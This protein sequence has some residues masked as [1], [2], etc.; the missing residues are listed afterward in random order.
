[1]NETTLSEDQNAQI[2]LP[3]G[4][5]AM[6]RSVEYTQHIVTFGESDRAAESSGQSKVLDQTVVLGVP[7]SS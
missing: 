1:M 2:D 7:A 6:L 5:G 3:I 4:D